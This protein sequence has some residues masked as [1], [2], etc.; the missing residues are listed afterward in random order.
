MEAFSKMVGDATSVISGVTGAT[1]ATGANTS[2]PKNN[3]WNTATGNKSPHVNFPA[4]SGG[5]GA[6]SQKGG[7]YWN[8]KNKNKNKSKKN[9]NRKNKTRKNRK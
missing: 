7:R 4:A 1:G 6:P 2:K 8:K 5:M 3:K 9:R